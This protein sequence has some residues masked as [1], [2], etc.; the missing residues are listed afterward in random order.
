MI[1]TQ[2]LASV[3]LMQAR[4]TAVLVEVAVESFD[5]HAPAPADN[6]VIN[7]G[8]PDSDS[9][10]KNRETV[11]KRFAPYYNCAPDELPTFAAN[12]IRVLIST[13]V[14]SEGLNLQGARLLMNYD[15]HWNPVRLMQREYYS[16]A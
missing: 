7:G 12:Q 1:D 11:I 6:R 8:V 9:G 4:K 13:D 16:A 10:S 5:D 3:F 14:L 15:L 2:R